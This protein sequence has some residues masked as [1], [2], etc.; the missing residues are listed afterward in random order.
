M[1]MPM[2]GRLSLTAAPAVVREA[3]AG[4]VQAL[5]AVWAL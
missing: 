1:A 3:P 4:G 2:N 5:W